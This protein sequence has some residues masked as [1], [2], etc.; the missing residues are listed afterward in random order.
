MPVILS[1]GTDTGRRVM[2]TEESRIRSENVMRG[3]GSI[4]RRDGNIP[5]GAETPYAAKW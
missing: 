1:P 2:G 3:D 5:G 4:V